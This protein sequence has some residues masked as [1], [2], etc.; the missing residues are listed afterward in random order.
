MASVGERVRQVLRGCTPLGLQ[1]R[2]RDLA[3]AT[4]L[5]ATAAIGAGLADIREAR[6]QPAGVLQDEKAAVRRIVVALHKSRTFR[7]DRPFAKAVIGSAEVADVLP[8]SDQTLY[9]Q[10][11]RSAPPTSRCSI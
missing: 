9:I 4:F 3:L 6:S 5:G 7:L 2:S 10:G 8:M 11:K 1:R